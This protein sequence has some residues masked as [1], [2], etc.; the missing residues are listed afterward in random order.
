MN[1]VLVNAR[2]AKPLDEEMMKRVVASGARIVTLEEGCLPGGFG[3]AVLEWAAMN[4][5]IPARIS[6]IAMPD[7]FVE[8]GARTI[9]LD[10]NDL[11]AGRVAER[12][13][14][15]CGK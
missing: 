3:A 7:R 15:L 14:K 9:L 2:S 6:C 11:S 8:H 13:A 5:T 10:I 1:P 12:I 4:A